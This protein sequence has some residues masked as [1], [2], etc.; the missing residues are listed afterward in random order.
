MTHA[1]VQPGFNIPDFTLAQHE[2]TLLALMHVLVGAKV[3]QE[4]SVDKHD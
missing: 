2:H 1:T 4:V 3:S